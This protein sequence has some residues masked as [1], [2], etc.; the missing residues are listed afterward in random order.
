VGDDLREGKPTLLASL[1]AA[2]ASA[3]QA[4][5]WSAHFGSAHLLESDVLV[6]RKVIEATGA[7]REVEST[8]ARL[9]TV[10]HEALGALPLRP[11]ATEALGDLAALATR[12]DR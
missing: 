3:S 9:G 2:R 5:L 4:E 7:R 1:A 12:R 10:A 11:A 6:L 8:I